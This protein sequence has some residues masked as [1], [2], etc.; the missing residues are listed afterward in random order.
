MDQFQSQAPGRF[1][2]K[3]LDTSLIKLC[4]VYSC[5]LGLFLLWVLITYFVYS[6][7]RMQMGNA[8]EK[9]GM[10]HFVQHITDVLQ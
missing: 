3:V 5:F 4:G 8:T 9:T 1:V 10:E 7:I 6:P 2:D